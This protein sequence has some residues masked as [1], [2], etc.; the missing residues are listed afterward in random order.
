MAPNLKPKQAP[1]YEPLNS[2]G[3][4]TNNS[5]QQFFQDTNF[6][7]NNI[8]DNATP[9]NTLYFSTTTNK[10]CYKDA[11]GMVHIISMS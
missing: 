4:I 9:N 7:V 11:Q 10:L 6:Y 5:W 3:P 2:S 8:S 1:L